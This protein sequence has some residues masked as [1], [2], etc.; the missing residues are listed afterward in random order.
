[1]K[2]LNHR[3]FDEKEI[4][5]AEIEKFIYCAFKRQHN[6][7]ITKFLPTLLS[8]SKANSITAGLGVN[9]ALEGKLFIEQYLKDDIE[10][11]ISKAANCNVKRC[12]VVEVGNLAATSFADLKL[13]FYVLTAFLKGSGFKWVVF[14]A[15][16]TLLNSCKKLSLEPV[17]LTDANPEDVPNAHSWGNY[18]DSNP[19]VV[20]GSIDKGF[21]LLQKNAI[22]TSEPFDAIKEIWFNSYQAGKNL[23]TKP[24]TQDFLNFKA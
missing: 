4:S 3:Y 24:K 11:E 23:N 15:A 9:A 18:Y 19:K 12:E 14:T 13:L 21:S 22:N 17:F 6:A 16:P 7:S 2:N 5:R 8:I 10:I 1:M 20:F